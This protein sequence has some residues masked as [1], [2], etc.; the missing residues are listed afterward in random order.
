GGNAMAS[1]RLF[2][3]FRKTNPSQKRGRKPLPRAL[4]VEPLETRDLLST[5]PDG[6]VETQLIN[7]VNPTGFSF[8]PDGRMFVANENGTV[9]VVHKDGSKASQPFVSVAVDSF[10]DRGLTSIIVDPNYAQNHYV[11]I[12]YTAAVSTNPNAANNGAPT[13]LV[14]YTASS[15]NP[16][17]ADTS[18]AVTIIDGVPSPNGIH[19]GGFMQFGADGMLY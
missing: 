6:F 2:S 19:V 7:G 13:R 18:S 15:S 16:D 8:A 12:Y 1:S 4:R 10:R 9:T 3:W 5:L 17:V 14:R 11:Y